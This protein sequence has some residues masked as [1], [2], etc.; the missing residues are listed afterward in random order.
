MMVGWHISN[1]MTRQRI[2][3]RKRSLAPYLLK[4]NILNRNRLE[5]YLNRFRTVFLKPVYGRGGKGVIKVRRNGSR[6]RLHQGKRAIMLHGKR[7]L[8]N[9]V[10]RSTSGKPYLIQK[11]V[12]LLSLRGRPVDFRVLMFKPQNEWLFMGIMGRLA[13]PNRIVTN[14]S[15]GGKAITLKEALRDSGLSNS[16]CEY[17][18]KKLISLGYKVAQA[19]S[20]VS[21]VRKI[22][23]DVAIDKKL[24]I[25]ILE[26][27]TDPGYNLFRYHKD[28]SLYH[29]IRG[30]SKYIRKTYYRR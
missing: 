20:R 18:E 6:Y 2:L 16:K 26:P 21:K 7:Y 27:N 9:K 14:Y 15:A 3:V 25:W 8:L 22:G 23:I 13:S 17:V 1:K 19:F 28:K 11:G 29:R 30:F 24:N 12:K 5:T 10:K 4:T